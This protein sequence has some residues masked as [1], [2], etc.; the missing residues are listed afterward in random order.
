MIELA[1]TLPASGIGWHFDQTYTD[2]LNGWTRLKQAYDATFKTDYDGN[3]SEPVLWDTASKSIVSNESLDMLRMLI[4][5]FIESA[6]RRAPELRPEHLLSEIETLSEYISNNLSN[7]VYSAHFCEDPEEKESQMDTIFRVMDEL[8]QRLE[9]Q[10]F[11]NG[12]QLTES[13]IVLFPTLTRFESVY[14]PLFHVDRKPLGQYP[15]LNAYIR[16]VA[17]SFQLENTVR[18]EINIESYYHSPMLNPE[19]ISPP[20]TATPVL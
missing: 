2:T 4:D 1:P 9:K 15:R 18:F 16:D 7:L 6:D 19:N 17:H 8:E 12:N 11:L 20:V 5:A 14:E 13:D 3:V 10:R